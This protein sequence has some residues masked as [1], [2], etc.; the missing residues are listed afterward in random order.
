MQRLILA[1]ALALALGA[2]IGAQQPSLPP[3]TASLPRDSALHSGTLPNGLRYYIRRNRL[4]AKRAELRLV[5]N[6]GSV[7]ER[8]DQ[9]GYAH[10]LEHTAFNGTTHFAKND[11][12]SYL[13]T[14]GV[15]FGADLNA[16]TALD[17]TI[18]I[19]PVPT[20]SAA[21]VA[22]AFQILG[23]WARGQTLDSLQVVGERG[24][25]REEWRGRKGAGDRVLRQILPVALK[26]S[27][28]AERLPIGTDAS[29]MGAQPSGLRAFYDRWYRP[30]LMAVI[31]V[32]D[33]EPAVIE[34]EIRAQFGRL[35][36]ARGP[37]ARPTVV[38]PDNA[39]PLVVVASDKELTSTSV[40][41]TYKG[42]ATPTRTVGDYRRDLLGQLYTGML[43][44]RF[45]EI[46]Q[47]PDAP[48]L[49]ANASK[50]GFFARSTSAF[51]LSA[52]VR[53]GGAA[54]GLEALLAETRR[55]DRF[56]FLQ[57]ELDRA[58]ANLL[59]SYERAYAERDRT[60]SGAL[61]QEYIDNFLRGDAT[62]SIAT[63]YQLVQA[64]M[65]TI[66]LADVNT[67]AKRWITDKNRVV[68]V[69]APDK[70]GLVLP[71]PAQLVAAFGRAAAAP[72][73]A[74]VENVSS[75]ALLAHRPT[76]GRVTASR[77]LPGTDVVE[78]T[79][80]NGA[81]VLVKP[82][83]FKAD[84]V[85]FGAYAPG[86][87]SLAADADYM[88]ASLATQ[89]VSLGGV[90]AFSRVDLGK[91]LSGKAVR[92]QPTMSE[93]SEGLSGSASPKDLETLLQ[94]AYLQFTAPRED[95]SAYAAFRNQ[96]GP[97]LQNRGADPGS[98]F[99][100]TVAVVMSQHDFRTRPLGTSTFAEV[101]L[102][103]AFAFYRAR[104]AD[105]GAFTFVFVGNVDTITLRPL[106]EHY[107]A[108]LPGVGRK[109]TWA[110]VSKGPPEGPV[111]VTVRK[112]RENKATTVIAFT[113]PVAY[114]PENRFALRALTDYLQ[115]R[116][117]ETL[118]EQLG[119]S[120]SPSVGSR[121][122]DVPRAEYAIQV[123]FS[124]SPENVGKLTPAVDALIDTLLR[125]GPSASDVE[126]VQAQ[127]IRQR[128]TELKQNAY[129]FGNILARSQ[130]GEDIA[131]LAAPY[132]R[133]IH[134]LT[135]AMIHEAA[136]RY[137][138]TRNRARFVLLPEIAGGAGAQP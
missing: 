82:T 69:A 123:L 132:D 36:R 130:S 84:E 90:G 20:D 74:Y 55:V 1:G 22:R 98:V 13:Q 78:W 5:V 109:E 41:V 102:D 95:T 86:G 100:D 119:G 28:Y 76:P 91:K 88:S 45:S 87:T 46:A 17:E 104:F 31:A 58:K 103:R 64:M 120:Y 50:G 26:G 15:K 61:V 12:V 48:F 59:R 94:L 127:M 47:K 77:T 40:E 2:P 19:L 30:D 131:G 27:L 93:T 99:G 66:A 107:L 124:S 8:K 16:S 113:G 110:R 24:V 53:D 62:P 70:P 121:S 68:V 32:G 54:R 52:G 39:A 136:R 60:S 7:L 116:L 118:R 80:G 117:T 112:G 4:P 56:G 63:E 137:L 81:R 85:L 10:F 92:L 33:F 42:A 44:A 35:P 34:R 75:E 134:D 114:T 9:L 71:T 6:V 125:A 129:W 21:I 65:P 72:T 49:G 79:L 37:A 38:V 126:K 105:A 25:V 18:Y 3:A 73:T 96:I 101:S 11:L 138:D 128:E 57:S 106:V 14:I 111:E 122:S 23:D 115:I 108:S 135:P 83:D 133:M 43:N 97:F 67:Q 51:D 89:L 29:I